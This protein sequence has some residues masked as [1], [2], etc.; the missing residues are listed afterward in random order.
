MNFFLFHFFCFLRSGENT[1]LC[2]CVWPVTKLREFLLSCKHVNIPIPNVF[3]ANKNARGPVGL[4]CPVTS[5]T[6]SSEL[7][8]PFSAP[9]YLSWLSAAPSRLEAGLL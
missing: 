3:Y 6:S 1:T 2:V 5:M 4:Y 9:G 8:A 7:L